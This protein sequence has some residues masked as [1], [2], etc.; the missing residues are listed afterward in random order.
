MHIT[1]FL[2]PQHEDV[3]KARS[4]KG[5]LYETLVSCLPCPIRTCKVMDHITHNRTIRLPRISIIR[6]G[7]AP[8]LVLCQSRR[9]DNLNM[10]RM[11]TVGAL[12]TRM[13]TQQ[14]MERRM[15]KGHGGLTK[16]WQ[17][18]TI[19]DNRTIIR[20]LQAP[21]HRCHIIP[22]QVRLRRRRV[23]PV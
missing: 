21:P 12:R 20:L 5:E 15:V 9:Q 10:D 14:T 4:R 6:T 18:T 22:G 7:K 16:I 17:L 11:D 13:T 2:L 23:R 19:R 8:V 1:H 3:L